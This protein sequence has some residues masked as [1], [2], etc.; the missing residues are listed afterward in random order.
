MQQLQKKGQLPGWGWGRRA[1]RRPPTRSGL[2]EAGPLPG[3]TAG[4]CRCGGRL[5]ASPGGC[6]STRS[7]GRERRA[8][9]R[10]W[11][12]CARGRAPV[13]MRVSSPAPPTPS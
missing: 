5:E 12:F 7:S 1:S 3:A 2:L 6:E 13:S 11:V 9:Q 10:L 4:A 8:C